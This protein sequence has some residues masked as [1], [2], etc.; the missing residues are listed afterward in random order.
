MVYCI[1]ANNWLFSDFRDREQE[2]IFPDSIS[3]RIDHINIS[4]RFSGQVPQCAGELTYCESLDVYPYSHIK[5][6]LD[7]NNVLKSF[8]GQDEVYVWY[9]K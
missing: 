4:S 1:N 2:I 7:A 9:T 5:T 8:F 6:K 3:D